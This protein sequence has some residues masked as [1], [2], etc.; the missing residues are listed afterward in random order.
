MSDVYYFR[1]LIYEARKGGLLKE[2]RLRLELTSPPPMFAP[3]VLKIDYGEVNAGQPL[4]DPFV[5]DNAHSRPR[6]MTPPERE[7]LLAWM[8]EIW[9]RAT[10]AARRLPA[11]VERRAK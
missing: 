8:R 7:L 5:Q 4:F 11:L 6:D 1:R 2:E 9:I 10:G 3:D